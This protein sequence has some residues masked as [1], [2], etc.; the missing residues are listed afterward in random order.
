MKEV[1]AVTA[2]AITNNK[3]VIGKN[4]EKIFRVHDDREYFNKLTEGK[5][6]V[7]GINTLQTL[8]NAKP[9]ANRTNIILTHNRDIRVPGVTT[10]G[11]INELH[12]ALKGYN[13]DDVYLI[14]GENTFAELIDECK[15]AILTVVD[16]DADGD[17]E[18]FQHFP[19]LSLKDNWM[20]CKQSSVHYYQ[21]HSWVRVTYVN[22]NYRKHLKNKL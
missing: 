6:V 22:T 3:W 11:N 19:N 21:R 13:T 7:Y 10:V 4:H 9:L 8:P 17:P 2:L 14:G 1:T 20:S 5:I 15:T 16:D 12:Y 18:V